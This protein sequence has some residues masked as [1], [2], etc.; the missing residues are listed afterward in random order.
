MFVFVLRNQCLEFDRGIRNKESLAIRGAVSD[1]PCSRSFSLSSLLDH[2][3]I[4]KVSASGS[5][6]QDNR[7]CSWRP[8][9]LTGR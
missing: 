9:Q 3:A 8:V 1:C 4:T 5:T 6:A 2:L 7:W